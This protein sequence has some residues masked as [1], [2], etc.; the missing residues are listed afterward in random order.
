[1]NELMSDRRIRHRF[2][3]WYFAY[4]TTSPISYSAALL[5]DSLR[6][7]VAELDPSGA[8]P[9]LRRMVVIGH[10]QGGLLA[11]LLAVRSGDAFWAGLTTEPFDQVPFDPEIR[12]VL[13]RSLF[14]EPLPFVTRLIFMSTPHHGSYLASW[15]IDAL[16]P[17]FVRLPGRVASL[18]PELLELRLPQGRA[19]QEMK[20]VP[21]GV[22]NMTPGNW[23]LET[24]APMPLAPGVTAH[25]IIAVRGGAPYEDDNDGLVEYKSAHWP[26]AKTEKVILHA[27]HAV[28]GNPQAILEV[29][30]ILREHLGAEIP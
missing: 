20:R 4:G 13:R 11:H 18:A 28:A 19:K 21:T 12:E 10:S 7:A 15:R 22:D 2:E 8:D 1:V 25:S 14:V 16:T 9:H 27:S 17:W 24:L 3:F 26:Q 6:R 5:R 23:F 30:R 29:R